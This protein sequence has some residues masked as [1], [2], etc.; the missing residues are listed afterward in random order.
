MKNQYIGDIGDYGKY[1]LLRFFALRGIRIGVNWYLTD[2]DES[3]DGKFTNYLQVDSERVFD[4]VVFDGLKTIVN[5]YTR[6]ERTVQMV[7]AAGLIPGA[8]FY[9]EKLSTGNTQPSDRARMRCFWFT[10]SQAALWD[11]DLIFADPDNGITYSKT[12]GRKDCE[13]YV[14]PQEIAKYYSAGKDVVFYCHKGRRTIDAWE[15]TIAQIKEYAEH[16][17]LFVLTF[18]KGTQRS[19]VFVTHPEHVDQYESM[20]TSFVTST[21]WGERNVFTREESIE[22]KANA[23]PVVCNGKVVLDHC[24]IACSTGFAGPTIGTLHP[25]GS[26]ILTNEDGTITIVPPV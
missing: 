20:I 24:Q 17:R 15:S 2:K 7:Q 23:A 18:H 14:L 19:Y 6:S 1:S 9:D 22:S 26:K 10:S 4:P 12:Q 25:K 5:A 11:A 3:S 21:P 8:L 13:K 16:A